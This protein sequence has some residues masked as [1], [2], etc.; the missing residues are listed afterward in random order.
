[1]KYW[2]VNG[3]RNTTEGATVNIT[4]WLKAQTEVKAIKMFDDF[5]ENNYYTIKHIQRITKK[6]FDYLCIRRN[7]VF[8]TKET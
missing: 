5:S 6:T 2:L 3:V 4:V 8:A 7:S 1:M